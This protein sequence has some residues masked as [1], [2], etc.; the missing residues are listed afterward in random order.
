MFVIAFQVGADP[1]YAELPNH[2]EFGFKLCAL[3]GL[4]Y[5]L[6]A[7]EQSG[8]ATGSNLPEPCG[9]LLERA[10]NASHASGHPPRLRCD[11]NKAEVF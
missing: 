3:C 4:T 11:G 5:I 6:I 2:Q 8:A 9:I 7:A 1:V 10:I